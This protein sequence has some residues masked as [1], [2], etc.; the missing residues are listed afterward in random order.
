MGEGATVRA[1]D[2][3]RQGLRDSRDPRAVRTR[4]RFFDAATRLA[5]EG[6]QVSVSDLTRRVG[7]SRAVF[8]TH[9]TD[10]S[11]LAS[12]LQEAQIAE[13]ARLARIERDR[14]VREALRRAHRG[15]V[16]HLVT[17]RGFYSAV[18]ALPESDAV[19]ARI[20]RAM[21]TAVQEHLRHLD[22]EPVRTRGEAAAT[23]LGYAVAGLVVT[24]LRGEIEL[25]R[26]ELVAA[27]DD[28]LPAWMY[29]DDPGQ[30]RRG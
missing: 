17:H 5:T 26:D 14:D 25:G 27:L 7:M 9:F 15:L 12:R 20:A 22:L 13:I 30:C 10:L 1:S 4:A 6:R 8:Y 16:D 19:T 3:L 2:A 23:Y 18:L 21:A 28:L 11:D 24:W 29:P